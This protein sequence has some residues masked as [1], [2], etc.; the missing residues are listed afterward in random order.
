MIFPPKYSPSLK[1]YVYKKK[2]QLRDFLRWRRCC[3]CI[4]LDPGDFSSTNL[5]IV[6]WL[7]TKQEKE[8]FQTVSM[9][10]CQPD[11]QG[12]K[13]KWVHLRLKGRS[14]KAPRL[15]LTTNP[16]FIN[17]SSAVKSVPWLHGTALQRPWKDYFNTPGWMSWFIK[18]QRLTK[19]TRDFFADRCYYFYKMSPLIF[20]PAA[21][22]FCAFKANEGGT[23]RH[24]DTSVCRC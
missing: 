2:S 12:K 7:I 24:P 9:I 20:Q 4:K 3:L 18:Q 1:K 6:P 13:S 15:P 23:H 17:K 14:E 16:R 10:R 11:T 5:P 21:S 8:A 22:E 19:A